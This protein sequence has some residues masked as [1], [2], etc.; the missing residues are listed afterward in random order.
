MRF[1]V[2]LLTLAASALMMAQPPMRTPDI[3]A[4]KTYLG[5]SDAQ[6]TTLQSLRTQEM[7]QVQTLQTQIQAKHT[8]LQKLLDAGSTNAAQIG[9]LMIDIQALQK[10]FEAIHTNYRNQAVATL[11]DAQKTKLKALDDASK[12]RDEIQEANFLNL[13]APAP[14]TG[15]PG[16]FMRGPAPMMGPGGPGA[17]GGAGMIMRRPNR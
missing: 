12:L 16:P 7:S 6:V 14:G 15:A 13:L 9:Q 10:Q 4:V 1:K 8:D 5:L 3:T 11:T 2:T 17:P